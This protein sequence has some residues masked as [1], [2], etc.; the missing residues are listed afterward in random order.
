MRSIRL[1]SFR[2]QIIR[3]VVTLLLAN[4]ASVRNVHDE[5]D[6]EVKTDTLQLV[7]VASGSLAKTVI[8]NESSAFYPVGSGQEGAYWPIVPDEHWNFM[9]RVFFPWNSTTHSWCGEKA[10][11][12]E[13]TLAGL[14]YNKV[15]KAASS[16]LAGVTLQWQ[17]NYGR[18]R[19]TLNGEAGSE[20]ASFH[21][22]TFLREIRR[23]HDRN[24]ARSFMFS[25][26][27]H[28]AHRALSW[29]FYE[30]QPWRGHG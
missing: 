20:C 7:E 17:K 27:R 29:I 8:A 19:R 26:I 28:P 16:T 4:F 2:K 10:D 23:F 9:P 30:V 12:D 3:L 14:I 11:Y 13:Y 25:S 6:G 22:H 15:H 18:Y 24:R 21:K 1:S 5:H